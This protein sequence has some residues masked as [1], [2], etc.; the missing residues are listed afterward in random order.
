MAALIDFCHT[1]APDGFE[2]LVGAKLGAGQGAPIS[3]CSKP[4][5]GLG[6]DEI[7]QGAHRITISAAIRNHQTLLHQVAQNCAQGRIAGGAHGC[8]GDPAQCILFR[9]RK[10][11]PVILEMGLQFLRRALFDL[12]YIHRLAALQG[13]EDMKTGYL[14]SERIAIH[15]AKNEIL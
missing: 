10:I 2:Y 8:F 5:Y 1:A 6:V 13:L 7:C 11:M 12:I 15:Q 3:N 4:G 9:Q 14:D